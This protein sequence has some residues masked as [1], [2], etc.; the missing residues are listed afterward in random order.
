MTAGP[1]FGANG[2]DR[3][4]PPP[5]NDLHDYHAA[6]NLARDSAA[7]LAGTPFV[8]SVQGAQFVWTLDRGPVTTGEARLPKRDEEIL[9]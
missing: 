2:M 7:K 3:V 1:G 6:L 5:E 4:L 9:E 8:L